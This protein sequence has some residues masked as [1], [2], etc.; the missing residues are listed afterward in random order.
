M[1]PEII[2]SEFQRLSQ[3]IAELERRT[4]SRRGRTNLAGAAQYLNRSRET[5]RKELQAGRGPRGTKNGRFWSFSYDALD[6]YA[7]QGATD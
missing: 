7:E 2:N 4:P 5:L 3:R 6:E 1:S